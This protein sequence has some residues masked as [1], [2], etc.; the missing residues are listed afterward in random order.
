VHSQLQPTGQDSKARAQTWAEVAAQS[1]PPSSNRENSPPPPLT[2]GHPVY[3]RDSERPR[4]SFPHSQVPRASFARFQ[5]EPQPA[6]QNSQTRLSAITPVVAQFPSPPSNKDSIQHMI[7]HPSINTECAP[8]KQPH[9]WASHDTFLASLD[10]PPFPPPPFEP[11]EQQGL[12]PAFLNRAF[13]ETIP[14][15]EQITSCDQVTESDRNR[16]SEDVWRQLVDTFP[17][18]STVAIGESWLTPK[19][20]PLINAELSPLTSFEALDGNE[21][22]ANSTALAPLSQPHSPST[23]LPRPAFEDQFQSENPFQMLY[24][25]GRSGNKRKRK[26]KKTPHPECNDETKQAPG[27]ESGPDRGDDSAWY[28]GWI[29]NC[30]I[31]NVVKISHNH[32]DWS[33]IQEPSQPKHEPKFDFTFEREQIANSKANSYFASNGSAPLAKEKD[34]LAKLFEK[35]RGEHAQTITV[36]LTML[37]E[38]PFC[39]IHR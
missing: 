19:D 3:D 36:E 25:G 28:P 21:N 15:N 37:I 38:V 8:S 13:T 7:D 39:R 2:A 34:T 35:Y 17:Q 27:P 5:T 11:P 12:R 31:F 24:E 33:E 30:T 22:G 32:V 23:G 6:S 29:S 20:R 1:R 26:A 16:L 4:V 9:S 14:T 10:S 18:D